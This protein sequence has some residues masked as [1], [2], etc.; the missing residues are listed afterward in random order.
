MRDY[1]P[2]TLYTGDD[3]PNLSESV[4]GYSLIERMTKKNLYFLYNFNFDCKNIIEDG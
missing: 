4:V 3:L 1:N 2:N